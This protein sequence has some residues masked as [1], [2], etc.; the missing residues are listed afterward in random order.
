MH[1]VFYFGNMIERDDLGDPD[2][3]GRVILKLILNKYVGTGSV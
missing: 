3:D 1:T 2:I